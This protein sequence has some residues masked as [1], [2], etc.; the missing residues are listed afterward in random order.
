MPAN[1]QQ[2]YY[3]KSRLQQLRGFCNTILLGSARQAAIK[4]GLDPSTITVQIKSLEADLNTKLFRKEGNKLIPTKEGELLYAMSIEHIYGIDNIFKRFTDK[5]SN[6]NAGSL[7]ISSHHIFSSYILPKYIKMFS[8]LYPNVRITLHNL[9]IDE[10]I[11]SLR[12]DKVDLAIYPLS[13]IP[14]WCSF[15]PIFTYNPVLIASKK[16]SLAKKDDYTLKDLEKQ[17]LIRVTS[18]LVTMP[19]FE[20]LATENKFKNILFLK[21]GTWEMLIGLVKANVGFTFIHTLFLGE[22]DNQLIVKPADKYLSKI[23][24]GIITK[25]GETLSKYSSDFFDILVK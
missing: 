8:E 5:I 13:K 22:K 17:T 6:K 3:K 14:T 18:E 7:D 12:D 25:K 24:Y 1:I 11:K 21:R 15:Q 2:F 10:A 23:T 16:N 20:K 19:G 4:M 9:T